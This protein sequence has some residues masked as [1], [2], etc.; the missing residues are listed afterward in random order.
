MEKLLRKIAKSFALSTGMD[1]EDFYQEAYIAYLEA[2]KTYNPER[3][4]VTTHIWYCVH[5]HLKNYLKLQ[6]EEKALSID[7][8]QCDKPVATSF[9][10]DVLSTEAQEIA[11]VIL[12]NPV[13]FDLPSRY[14]VKKKIKAVL[15]DQGWS[16]KRIFSGF[17]E[18]QM[19]YSN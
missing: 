4:A 2:M 14:E 1:Y 11:K 16:A 18:L 10:L 3:G 15:L 17:R 19:I 9:S 7:D 6:E 8:I 13:S 12:S 5:N